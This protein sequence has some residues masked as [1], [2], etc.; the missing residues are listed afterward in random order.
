MHRAFWDN[1]R[2]QLSEDPPVYTQAF[3]LLQE[4]RDQLL[5]ITLPHQKK[6][7]QEISEKL[8][9]DL[10]KQ[11]AEHGVLN[12]EEWVVFACNKKVLLGLLC[13]FKLMNRV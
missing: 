6:L 3:V 2:E 8:D 1:L 10:I 5:E 9:F 12:F 4:I 7:R 13:N 11:Q